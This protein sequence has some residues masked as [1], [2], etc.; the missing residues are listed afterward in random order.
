[1]VRGLPCPSKMPATPLIVDDEANL[2]RTLA[3]ILRARG[4]S[5][6]EADDGD[7][8]RITPH[9]Q[10]GSDPQRSEDAKSRRRRVPATFAQPLSSGVDTCDRYHRVRLKP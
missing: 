2:R 1:M 6:L 9:N 3:E 5:I 10:A 7:R 8:N 4:Y